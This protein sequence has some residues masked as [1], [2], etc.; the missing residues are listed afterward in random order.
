[1]VDGLFN[2]IFFIIFKLNIQTFIY[3]IKNFFFVLRKQFLTDFHKFSSFNNFIISVFNV[4]VL[5]QLLFSWSQL[6][7]KCGEVF[8]VTE[9]CDEFGER[10][11]GVLLEDWILHQ[12]LQQL[13]VVLGCFF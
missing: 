6:L 11:L 10:L 4:Q 5:H 13:I 2:K 12:V 8:V 3:K 1:M 7:H 9:V